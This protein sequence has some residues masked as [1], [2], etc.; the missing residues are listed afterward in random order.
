MAVAVISDL[1]L[2]L[3]DASDVFGH[4]DERFLRFLSTLEDSFEQIV[5]LGDVWETLTAR[6]PLRPAEGLR[7]AREAHPELAR[8]FERP[9]YVYVHGNH[10]LVARDVDR[11]PE[12]L[13]LTLGGVRILLTHGHLQDPLVRHARWVSETGVYLGALLLRAG[14]APVQRLFAAADRLREGAS[15]DPAS[16]PFQRWAVDRARRREADVV[17]TGHTHRAAREEHAATLFLNSG[18]CAG[19]RFSFLA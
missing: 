17:V 16:C 3:G 19:G 13:V 11:A 8:R 7:R 15:T 4:D 12:E 14:L 10:D 9:A 1:H 18:S 5:L 6:G 2:G